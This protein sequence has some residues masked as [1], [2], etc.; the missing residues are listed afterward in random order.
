M[1]RLGQRKSRARGPIRASI[2]ISELSRE[3]FAMTRFV[4][5]LILWL[6]YSAGYDLPIARLLFVGI[7]GYLNREPP[8]VLDAKSRNWQEES[9]VEWHY[10][11]LGKPMQNGLVE[12]CKR[13][14]QDECLKRV[15]LP[16][17]PW[18]ST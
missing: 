7:F 8:V 6:L 12:C 17:R 18:K 14:P 9:Q 4:T 1:A 11:V 10:I 3:Q 16:T 5:G 2:V 13:R 15:S